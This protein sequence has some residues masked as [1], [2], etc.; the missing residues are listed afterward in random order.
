MARRFKQPI[1]LVFGVMLGLVSMASG[2]YC[3]N[4][5]KNPVNLAQDYTVITDNRGN[6][7]IVLLIWLASPI[8]PASPTSEAGKELLDKYIVL[9]VVHA[10]FAKDGTATFDNIDK[11]GAR[12]GDGHPLAAL[13]TDTMPPTIVGA[14]A[15][16]QSAFGRSLGQLGQGTKW[17]VFDSGN[18]HPC[19]RGRL[20]VPFANEIYTYDTP[21][22]GCPAA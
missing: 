22:P 11:L 5:S 3:R 1:L 18:T 9:G 17:F 16:L 19:T 14:L 13:S 20:S 15:A 6:G 4:W 21:I 2:A 12:G 10:H 7:E 8:V